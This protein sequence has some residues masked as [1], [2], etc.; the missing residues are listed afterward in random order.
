MRLTGFGYYT[1]IAREW[2]DAHVLRR[3]GSRMKSNH[4][5][6]ELVGLHTRIVEKGLGNWG[7]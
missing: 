1:V 6:L 3:S 5:E 7:V 4:D 2:Q